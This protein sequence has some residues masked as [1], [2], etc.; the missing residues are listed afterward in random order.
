MA[1]LS[2]NKPCPE[3]QV[4]SPWRPDRRPDSHGDLASCLLACLFHVC[5]TAALPVCLFACLVACLSL[6]CLR[7]CLLDYLLLACRPPCNPIARLPVCK[8]LGCSE[9]SPPVAC[10]RGSPRASLRPACASPRTEQVTKTT[11]V[12]CKWRERP[13]RQLPQHKQ[14]QN[15]FKTKRICCNC[16]RCFHVC[17]HC[18]CSCYCSCCCCSCC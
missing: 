5:Q 10:A 16:C 4:T 14:H 13:R 11:E 17:C 8:L 12:Q 9:P 7:A 2:L 6:A 18:C 15:K 3:L 1:R